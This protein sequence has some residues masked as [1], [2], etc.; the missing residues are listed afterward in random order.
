M[1]IDALSVVLNV[2]KT[3]SYKNL[4]KENNLLKDLLTEI[5]KNEYLNMIHCAILK[6]KSVNCDGFDLFNNF[7]VGYTYKNDKSEF[8]NFKNRESLNMG[9]FLDDWDEGQLLSNMEKIRNISMN[10]KKRVIPFLQ[11]MGCNIIQYPVSNPHSHSLTIQWSE[12]NLSELKFEA[13]KNGGSFYESI[14]INNLR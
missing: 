1:N 12:K 10:E 9:Y 13:F 3:E 5:K 14:C 8:D 11:K 6:H 7:V 2:E 4:I